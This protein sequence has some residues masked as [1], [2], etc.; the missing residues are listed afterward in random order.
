[1]HLANLCIIKTALE[2]LCR[3]RGLTLFGASSAVRLETKKKVI[4]TSVA[5]GGTLSFGPHSSS[6]YLEKERESEQEAI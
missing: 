1:M 3:I 2:C 6:R 5:R 4:R